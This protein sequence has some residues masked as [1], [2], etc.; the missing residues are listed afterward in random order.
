[1]ESAKRQVAWKKKYIIIIINPQNERKKKREEKKTE[2]II[3]H[4]LGTPKL[5]HAPIISPSLSKPQIG[6]HRLN[7]SSPPTLLI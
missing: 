7:S 3:Y 4:I 1:M 6:L 2:P 5:R